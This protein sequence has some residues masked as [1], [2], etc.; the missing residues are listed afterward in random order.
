[1]KYYLFMKQIVSRVCP[2]CGIYEYIKKEINYI[3]SSLQKQGDNAKSYM[4]FFWL[5]I[6]PSFFT[7]SLSKTTLFAQNLLIHH[8]IIEHV[9]NQLDDLICARSPLPYNQDEMWAA[10]QEE[11]VSFSKERLDDLFN[12]MLCHVTALV[13]ARGGHTEY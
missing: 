4:Q 12:S 7:I 11:W 1:M 9:W 13:K 8:S 10:L 3:L 6:N 2:G 5:H